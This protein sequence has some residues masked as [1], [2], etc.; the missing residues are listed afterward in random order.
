MITVTIQVG[1]AVEEFG[2]V[3][4]SARSAGLLAMVVGYR[5]SEEF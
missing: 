1:L 3:E 2:V 4:T 5:A